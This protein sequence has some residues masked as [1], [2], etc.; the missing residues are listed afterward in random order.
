MKK[1]LAQLSNYGMVILLHG[2]SLIFLSFILTTAYYLVLNGSACPLTKELCGLYPTE[3]II[4]KNIF[5]ILVP[6][7]LS[8]EKPFY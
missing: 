2:L 3:S 5:I 1:V 6:E 4:G 8:M 7:V